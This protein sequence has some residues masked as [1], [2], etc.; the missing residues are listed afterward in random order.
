LGAVETVATACN[1]VSTVARFCFSGGVTDVGDAAVALEV[2]A[3][4]PDG[5]VEAVTGVVG[6]FADA[7]VVGEFTV[8]TA[9]AD[10]QR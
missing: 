2:F 1:A 4:V 5:V 6:I 10:G 9:G 8:A 3:E 7:L